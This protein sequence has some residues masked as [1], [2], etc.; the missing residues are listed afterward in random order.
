MYVNEIVINCGSRSR[1]KSGF[2]GPSFWRA[3]KRNIEETGDLFFHIGP[4]KVF[5]E[6][7]TLKGSQD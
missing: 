3:M 2:E 4:K 5:V 7:D 1:S 6:K